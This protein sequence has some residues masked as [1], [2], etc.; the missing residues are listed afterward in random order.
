M[1][2]CVLCRSAEEHKICFLILWLINTHE[3]FQMVLIFFKCWVSVIA[4]TVDASEAVSVCD[5]QSPEPQ[6]C[7]ASENR[8]CCEPGFTYNT[9]LLRFLSYFRSLESL[10]ALGVYYSYMFIKRMSRWWMWWCVFS[11]LH[12]LF[13]RLRAV[14]SCLNVQITYYFKTYI[15]IRCRDSTLLVEW[16]RLLDLKIISE[17][18]EFILHNENVLFHILHYIFQNN[19]LI[20]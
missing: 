1:K 19:V 15:N 20:L 4:G 17:T 9:Y 14:H 18:F 16:L 10:Q 3:Q 6:M 5:E 11:C 13:Y 12:V 2:V 8:W 7:G